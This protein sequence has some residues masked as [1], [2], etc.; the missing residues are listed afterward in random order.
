MGPAKRL[1]MVLAVAAVVGAAGAG[2]DVAGAD[3]T[4][5]E[6]IRAA[7]AA[8]S[9]A[10]RGT[11]VQQT[12]LPE[13][14]PPPVWSDPAWQTGSVQGCVPGQYVRGVDT[15]GEKLVTFTFD[16]GPD[17]RYTVPIM[18]AFAERGLTATFFMIGINLRA[19]PKVGRSVV[20]RGFA[21][22]S[23]SVSHRYGW[24]NVSDEVA[25]MNDVIAEVLGV[26]TPYFRAP[27]LGDGPPIDAALVRAGMCH[28]STDVVLGDHITPR[29]SAATLCA[30]FA[31]R[32]K[33]GMI[34]LLHDGGTHEPTAQAVP[35]MLDVAAA[36][37]YRVVSL[38]ELLNAGVPY[39]GRRWN[40]SAVRVGAQ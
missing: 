23:H 11:S 24:A 26:R 35:C 32:L 4:P 30:T 9:S 6:P 1:V 5:D 19:Y 16:D 40:T 31:E 39:E 25:P 10:A 2:P 28:L 17:P 29:R 33:P 34:A 36:M 27:G 13:L 20:E 7:A 3:S 12:P 37:G 14:P 15:D 22:A 18:D 21:V 38:A 8:G